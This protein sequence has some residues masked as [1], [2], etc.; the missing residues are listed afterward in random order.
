MLNSLNFYTPGKHGKNGDIHFSREFVKHFVENIPAKEYNFW[1]MHSPKLLQ[2]IKNL[3]YKNLRN[4]PLG[5]PFMTSMNQMEINQILS[6]YKI[7]RVR[8]AV[9][10]KYKKIFQTARFQPFQIIDNNLFINVWVFAG[11]ASDYKRK[12][13]AA[14]F[15]SKLWLDI[16]YHKY[17]KLIRDLGNVGIK[18]KPLSPDS[19][20]YIPTIDYSVYNLEHINKFVS[21]CTEIKVLVCNGPVTSG[22]IANFSFDG[23]IRA[24]SKIV[25]VKVITTARTNIPGVLYT[26]DIIQ[27]EGGDLNEISYLSK[28]CGIIIGRGSGPF[29][30]CETKDNYFNNNKRMISVTNYKSWGFWWHNPTNMRWTNNPRNLMKLFQ[31][32][33]KEVDF[34][35]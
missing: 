1:H 9:R 22:Q 11:W 33:M 7:Q 31:Q 21:E 2:E 25:E 4:I 19:L 20:T 30:F 10:R 18:C 6:G 35:C 5:N 17:E 34:E 15:N 14:P 23:F 12:H 26:G 29:C 13:G 27:A 24:L 8:Q 3:K 16:N 28:F 32:C